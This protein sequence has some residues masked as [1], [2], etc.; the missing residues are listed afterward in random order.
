ML[1]EK[2]A[3]DPRHNA[4][5]VLAEDVV[6]ERVYQQWGMLQGDSSQADWATHLKGWTNPKRRRGRDDIFAKEAA[7]A[8][9]AGAEQDKAAAAA[10]EIDATPSQAMVVA[11]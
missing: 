8:T 1:Y 4:C 3:K 9:L 7:K 2:I 11:Q 5:K 6:E 10:D